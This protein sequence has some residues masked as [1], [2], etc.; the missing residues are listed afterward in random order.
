M[1]SWRSERKLVTMPVEGSATP[2]VV[3][4]RTFEKAKAGHIKAVVIGIVWKDGSV[5][6]DHSKLKMGDALF[7]LRVAS[8]DLDDEIF[9]PEREEDPL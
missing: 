8:Q 1:S 4:A 6:S 5:S 2:E 7:A 3:L 9:D